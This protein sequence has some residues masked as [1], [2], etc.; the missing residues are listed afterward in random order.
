MFREI[1]SQSRISS[2]FRTLALAVA[3]S[4]VVPPGALADHM[5]NHLRP[6]TNSDGQQLLTQPTN[7]CS[8]GT[9]NDDVRQAQP[10][11]HERGGA[12]GTRFTEPAPNDSE[13]ARPS[14]NRR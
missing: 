1:F 7:K 8:S 3:L 6:P 14:D 13:P 10:V 4:G 11:H 5:G 12:A 9:D 2:A